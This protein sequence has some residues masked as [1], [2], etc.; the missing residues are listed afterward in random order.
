MPTLVSPYPTAYPRKLSGAHSHY[1]TIANG[2][3]GLV[4]HVHPHANGLVSGIIGATGNLGGIVFSI[5]FRFE[6]SN[7]A[8]SIWI[9]GIITIL[10]NLV[11]CWIKPLPK[12]QIGGR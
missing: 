8:K 3:K 10:L 4:P 2:Y 7:Y 1:K 12:G 11:T 6:G 5:I 9:T